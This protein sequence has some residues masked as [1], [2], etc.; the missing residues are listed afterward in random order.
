LLADVSPGVGVHLGPGC[1]GYA[2]MAGI[3]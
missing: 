2:F 1:A 3:D